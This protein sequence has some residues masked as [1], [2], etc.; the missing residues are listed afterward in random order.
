V[1]R[2]DDAA[3]QRR[4]RP[5]SSGPQPE[6]A[7][8]IGPVPAHEQVSGH[9]FGALLRERRVAAGISQEQLAELAGLSIRTI[10]NLERDRV[11]RP[12]R[13]SI[14]LLATALGLTP[15][16]RDELA[17][18][19]HQL[20]VR[21]DPDVLEA[22]T[23]VPRQLPPAV[24]HFVGRRDVLNALTRIADDAAP[25]RGAVLISAIGGLAGVGKTALA[26][27]WAHQMAERFPDG[28]LYVNLRGFGPAGPAM[29]PDEAI[30]G[31]LD[32]LGVP[33]AQLPAGLDA[34]VARYR[35][36]LS[37][38][39]MLVVLDNAADD[40]QVRPLLPGEPGCLVIATSRSQL[41]GLAASTG[42]RLLALDLLTDTEARQLLAARLG[43]ERVEAEPEAVAEIV[44]LCGRLPLALAITASRAACRPHVLLAAL[45]AEFRDVRDR[46]DAL[47]TGDPATSARTV[48]SWSSRQLTTSAARMF[49]LLGLHPG[50][51][52]SA[53][54][55]A[56][57]AGTSLVQARRDLT[58]LARAHL[59]TE[60]A[61]GRH[62][63]HDLLRAY[64]AEEARTSDR[65]EARLAATGRVLDYYL[66]TAHGAALLLNPTREP[67][68]LVP[69]RPGVA[70]ERLAGHQRAMAWFEAEHRALL[71]AVT[72]AA[73]S[74]FDACA[75]QLPWT[76]ANFLDRRGLWHDWAAIERTGLAAAIRLDDTAGQAETRSLLAH[77]CAKLADYDQARA[78]LAECLRLHRQL[79]DPAGEARARLTLGWICERQDRHAD[80]LDHA[81]R[82]IAL[83]QEAGD[84]DG[85][86]SALN[87][88]GWWYSRLGDY[89]QAEVFCRRALALYRNVGDRIGEAC[90]WD[91]IG[92]AEHHLHRSVEAIEC[93]RRALG[94]F[95]ELA[96]RFNEASVLTHLGDARLVA[97]DPQ[98]ARRAWRLS[99]DILDD[100]RHPDADQVRARLEH[101]AVNGGA[102]RS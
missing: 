34:R 89:R 8:V 102:A 15:A 59:V 87:N 82:A 19:G 47:D 33:A 64:A 31:F 18:A 71:A 75:W 69:A 57:L 77:S 84:L 92:Y 50:P 36:M 95:R 1:D 6:A 81:D 76:M 99:L 54:A 80:A 48:F 39:R 100:L 67:L 55:A 22:S 42:A 58:E 60:H 101:A 7:T 46:L 14:A 25:R 10:S 79:G 68:T 56:C 70:P 53:P 16:D 66:H 2:S 21:P 23:P 74:G 73:E 40:A 26:V 38:R 35:S 45:A 17:R 49:R 32:A 65:E 85:Q 93:F 63:M 4:I 88:A 90:A 86:A 83:Y 44:G 98:Q 62:A 41:V 28:Q 5:P 11:R 52:I 30:R 43:S 94:I 29:T 37:G 51:D 91:S 96:D 72:L 9:G 20:P 61:A 3:E 24:T 97:G 27:H 12:H 78:E 13:D